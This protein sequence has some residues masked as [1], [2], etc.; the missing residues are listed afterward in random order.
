MGKVGRKPTST[1]TLVDLH[2]GNGDQC[3]ERRSAPLVQYDSDVASIIQMS[4]SCFR[5]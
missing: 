5:S 1:E 3:S 2:S 4:R